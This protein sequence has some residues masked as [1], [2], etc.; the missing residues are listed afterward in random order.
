M[1]I[2]FFTEIVLCTGF[3]SVLLNRLPG[4]GSLS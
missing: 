4:G 1:T 2:H 3:L